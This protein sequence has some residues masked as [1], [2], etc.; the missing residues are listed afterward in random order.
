MYIRDP[1]GNLVEIDWPDVTTLDRSVIT[2]IRRLDDDVKQT[3]ESHDATLYPAP[4]AMASVVSNV[5]ATPGPGPENEQKP[6]GSDTLHPAR[7]HPRGSR[8]RA[9]LGALR[10][11][12][13]Q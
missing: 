8:L 11:E 12:P 10:R 7:R 3:G 9:R 4:D 6:A 2:D 1:A 5:A 13:V